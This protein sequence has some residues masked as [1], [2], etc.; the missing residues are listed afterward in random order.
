MLNIDNIGITGRVVL[1]N[2][3]Y[4]LSDKVDQI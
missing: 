4:F 2:L 3:K 1:K